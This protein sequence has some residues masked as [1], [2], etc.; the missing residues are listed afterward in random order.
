MAS[1]EMTVDV[2]IGPVF[3]LIKDVLLLAGGTAALTIETPQERRDTLFEKAVTLLTESTRL[4]EA[5]RTMLLS[6]TITADMKVT[7]GGPTNEVKAGDPIHIVGGRVVGHA[8]EWK[9]YENADFS[10]FGLS[11]PV[12]DGI[13]L[14]AKMEAAKQALEAKPVRKGWEFLGAP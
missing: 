13:V 10:Q 4:M 5:E 12:L 2:K 7:F 8:L 6:N 11:D 3:Q 1:C 9:T 14:G